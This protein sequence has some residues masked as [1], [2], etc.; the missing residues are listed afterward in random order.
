MQRL[1]PIVPKESPQDSRDPAK[2]S[3]TVSE[4]TCESNAP[5][6]AVTRLPSM[7]DLREYARIAQPQDGSADPF[8]AHDQVR[9][10]PQDSD[11]NSVFATIAHDLHQLVGIPRFDEV[12]R[13]TTQFQPSVGGQRFVAFD[14]LSE[15]LE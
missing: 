8:V 11:G 6:P 9:T 13:R 15:L 10:T 5:P 14:D 1:P 7:R 4:I 2:P 3:R 12:L